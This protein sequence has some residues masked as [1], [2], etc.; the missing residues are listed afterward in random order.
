MLAQVGLEH[1][2]KRDD[3]PSGSGLRRAARASPG[4]RA[5]YDEQRERGLDHD[6]ALRALSNR[7][8]GILHGCLKTGTLYDEA[9]AWS[10]RAKTSEAA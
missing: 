6:A 8:V 9:T 4:A 3:A 5:C 7:L 1:S 10:H 2:G